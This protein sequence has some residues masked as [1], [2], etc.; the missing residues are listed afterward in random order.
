MQLHNL[1]SST[2]SNDMKLLELNR[3]GE[4]CTCYDSSFPYQETSIEVVRISCI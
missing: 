1:V 4:Y 3:L 2:R